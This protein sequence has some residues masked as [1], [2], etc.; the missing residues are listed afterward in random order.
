MTELERQ[1]PR[2]Y[3][4]P[5]CGLAIHG[6]LDGIDRY[7]CVDCRSEFKVM[8][9]AETGRAAFLAPPA[10]DTPHPLYLP[11]GSVRALVALALAAACWG[12][13][14]LGRQ[15]PVALL[16]LLLTVIGFYFGFRSHSGSARDRIFDPSVY[17][18]PPLFLPAGVIRK[19]LL[20]G[21]LVAACVLYFRKQ[22]S[23]RELLSFFLILFGLILGHLFG[24]SFRKLQGSGLYVFVG[25]CKAL[26]VL[27]AAAGVI[28]LILSGRWR[29]LRQIPLA[30]LCLIISFYFGSRS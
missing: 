23:D 2:Q 12:Q 22:L 8:L 30:V 1:T 21:F 29:E 28:L 25:H 9:D 16:S 10:P 17:A 20:G 26:V 14:L 3:Q 18:E 6:T 19:I 24:R 7:K 13:M 15:V 4:C 5:T 11:Q 27:A